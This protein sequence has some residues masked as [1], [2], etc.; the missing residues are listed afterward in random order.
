LVVG[1]TIVVFARLLP[2]EP[3]PRSAVAAGGG[4]VTGNSNDL[5]AAARQIRLLQGQVDQM[6]EEL[7]G[8]QTQI[9]SWHQQIAL[10]DEML[11]RDALTECPAFLREE[12]TVRA[13]QKI[14][15]EADSS[16][17][18]TA[19]TQDR[20]S[21]AAGVARERLRSKLEALRDQLQTQVAD[22]ETQADAL[23]LRTHLQSQEVEYRQRQV[24]RELQEQAR[25]Q[26]PSDSGK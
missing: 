25:S 5:A 22:L 9:A 1:A 3:L 19:A 17:A 26:N 6:R 24:Q 13:L 14:I 2:K 12:T 7:A 20:L 18:T 23:R 15:R 16:P 8:L 11:A 4:L 10:L 21:T